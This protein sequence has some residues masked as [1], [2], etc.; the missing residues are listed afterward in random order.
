MIVMPSLAHMRPNCVSGL[1]PERFPRRRLAL[2]D[3]FPVAVQR[4]GNAVL[5]YPGCEQIG[6]GP[7][8]FLVRETAQRHT[9]RVIDEVHQTGFRAAFFQP[10]VVRTVELNQL[11]EVRFALAPGAMRLALATAAPQTRGEHPAPQCFARHFQAVVGCQM[12]RRQ[13]R[14]EALVPL[15][16]IVLAHQ[17]E[18]LLA[19]L[20]IG[21]VRSTADVTVHQ[22]LGPARTVTLLQTLRMAVADLQQL[23]GFGQLQFPSFHSAQHFAAPQLL[24]T[25][26][27][28]SH[29]RLLL[30]S[31]RVG[32][33]SIGRSWGHYHWASTGSGQVSAA[34]TTPIRPWTRANATE[35]EPKA[36]VC[37]CPGDALALPMA[38]AESLFLR[39][40]NWCKPDR[41]GRSLAETR[42]AKPKS[43][44]LANIV[45]FRRKNRAF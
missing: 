42:L 17:L 29:S 28:P 23:G 4:L 6:R 26:P 7:G 9:G 24:G 10:V 8:R 20:L 32:D 22:S 5:T 41:A 12:F 21:S 45:E 19:S 25:H 34:L 36:G 33:I 13:R 14:P 37:R 30:R 1:M 18:N 35:M 38:V 27:C 16:R 40:N 31:L 15:A 43:R 11:A 2:V 39:I 3:V 44:P